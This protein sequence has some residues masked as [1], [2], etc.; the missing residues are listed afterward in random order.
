[1]RSDSTEQSGKTKKEMHCNG[2]MQKTCF[3]GD[4]AHHE[5]LFPLFNEPK[6]PLPQLKVCFGFVVS[7]RSSPFRREKRLLFA[8]QVGR[9][10]KERQRR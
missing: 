7:Q 10:G 9:G 6:K 8:E 3:S 4:L 2:D 5:L 1:M